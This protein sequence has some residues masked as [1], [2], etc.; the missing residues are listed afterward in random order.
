MS[1]IAID[2]GGARKKC[3]VIRAV[4]D[5]IEAYAFETLDRDGAPLS[6][7]A[8]A[9]HVIVERPQQDGRGYGVPPKHLIDFTWEGALLAAAYAREG[10]GVLVELTPHDWK[11]SEHKS[12]QHVRLW[13]VLTKAE[14]ALLGGETTRAA[15]WK[16]REAGALKRWK[17]HSS[18]Y[19][20]KSFVMV[21][22]LDAAALYAV[23]AGRLQKAR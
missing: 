11:G 6:L 21:D 23:H 17:P 19:Y 14:R 18:A 22:V 10:G 7:D 8:R 13:G 15:I 12:Q 16:A 5:V 1:V 20:P 9:S 4:S 2:P 3:A